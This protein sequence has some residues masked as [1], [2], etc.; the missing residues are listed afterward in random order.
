MVPNSPSINPS[1]FFERK[2]NTSQ[3]TFGVLCSTKMKKDLIATKIS[4]GLSDFDVFGV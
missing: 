2:E 3:K 4:D 1:Q